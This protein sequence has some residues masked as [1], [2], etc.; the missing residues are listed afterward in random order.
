MSEIIKK[1]ISDETIRRTL[2]NNGFNRRVA[3]KKPF[4]S[5][6]NRK[7]RLKF[8]KKYVNECPEFWNNVLFSDE[9]KYNIFESDRKQM[10][11]RKVNTQ[12]KKENLC[13]TIKYGGGNVM[14]WRCMASGG[15]GN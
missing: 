5:E 7:K 12:P 13:A 1:A 10:V 11:W 8:T 3:R 2:Q 14:V 6:V 4:I 9:G 15:V